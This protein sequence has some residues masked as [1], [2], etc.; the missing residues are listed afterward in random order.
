MSAT[1]ESMD[2]PSFEEE[3]D[4]KAIDTLKRLFTDHKLRRISREEVVCGVQ[5]VWS[6]VSGLCSDKV[7]RILEQ[8]ADTASRMPEELIGMQVFSKSGHYITA[9]WMPGDEVFRYTIDGEHRQ[10]DFSAEEQP[11]LE[12]EQGYRK[13][14]AEIVGRTGWVKL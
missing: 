11:Y 1:A 5:V 14:I 2:F 9:Y 10:K 13:F 8:A 6:S 12:A 7:R 3:L 4:R